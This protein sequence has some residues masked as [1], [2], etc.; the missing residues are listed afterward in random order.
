[1]N[2]SDILAKSIR[3][4]ECQIYQCKPDEHGYCHVRL[5]GRRK[6]AHVVAWEAYHGRE[7]PRGC[8]V[9]HTCDHKNCIRDIH[10]ELKT[11]REHTA[12]HNLEREPLTF[13]R[14][15]G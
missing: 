13:R 7:V 9:H 15:N 12:E 5:N 11:I 10:L 6:L 2:S 3:S 8:S 4:G 14:A 1:M